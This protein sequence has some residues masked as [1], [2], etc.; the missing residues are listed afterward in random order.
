MA[1]LDKRDDE[2]KIFAPDG[3][4]AQVEVRQHERDAGA[5]RSRLW[6]AQSTN[7]RKRARDTTLLAMLCSFSGER[8]P[9]N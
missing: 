6:P 3:S 8:K 4:N 9:A 7:H 2:R 1:E 5:L